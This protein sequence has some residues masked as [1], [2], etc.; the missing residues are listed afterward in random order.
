V[1]IEIIDEFGQVVTDAAHQVT[2]TVTG[3]GELIGSGNASPFDMES[4]GK[5]VL[6]TFRGIAQAVIRPYTEPGTIVLKAE[7]KGLTTGIAE[8]RT[9]R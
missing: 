1:A 3:N 9:A 7:G 5:P 4:F 6:K 2:L 8:I